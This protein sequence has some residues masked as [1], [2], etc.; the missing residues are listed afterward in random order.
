M[1]NIILIGMPGSGKSTVGVLLAKVLGYGFLDT[2]L[3]LQQREG[4]LLQDL[5]DSRGMEGFLDAE[6]AAVR[7]VD[8]DHCVIAP[9]GSVVCRPGAMARLQALGRV[10]YLKLSPGELAGRLQNLAT[11]GVVM[12]PGQTVRDLYGRRAPLYERYAGLTVETGGLTLEE[13]LAALRRA[14]AEDGGGAEG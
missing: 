14:L 7:T 9:G 6:E 12:A 10:V 8:C 13:T 2:D 4:M 5:L 11:R 3:L 1:E